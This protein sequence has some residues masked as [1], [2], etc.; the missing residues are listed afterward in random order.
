MD[1]TPSLRDKI[2]LLEV[3]REG[4]WLI[5][6][7]LCEEVKTEHDQSTWGVLN[8]EDPEEVFIAEND[9]RVKQSV[10]EYLQFVGRLEHLKWTAVA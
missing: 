9:E 2:E 1:N 4:Y 10:R 3:C 7:D 6:L 8:I 5:H